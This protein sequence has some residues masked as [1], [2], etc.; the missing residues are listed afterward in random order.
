MT[1][2]KTWQVINEIIGKTE[3]KSI[4]L[5]RRIIVD[6]IETYDKKIISEKF[7]NYFINVG[8]TLAERIPPSENNFKS[9]HLNNIIYI[10]EYNLSDDEL[11]KAGVP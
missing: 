11:E 9:Y 6:N 3:I 4:N 5:P 2:K 7:N 1:A 8:P 10:I